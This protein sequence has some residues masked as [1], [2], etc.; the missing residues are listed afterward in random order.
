MVCISNGICSLEAQPFEIGKMA[1]I[2]SRT[3]SN[4]NKNIQIKNSLVLEWLGAWDYSY[5]PT[6]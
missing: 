4:Q 6:I 3:I 5:S 2:L 1:T